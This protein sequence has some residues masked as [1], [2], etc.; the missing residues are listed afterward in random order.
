MTERLGIVDSMLELIGHIPLVRLQ[1]IGSD[2]GAEIL[3]KPEFLNPSGSIK[4]RIAK[5]MIE[6]AEAA[7][8][9]RHG[10]TII[11]ATS[12]NTGT[13]L[14]FV[15]AVKG[16]AMKA[17][18]P[19]VVANPTRM[20]IMLAYGAEMN[21]V[22]T[23][24]PLSSGAAHGG[25][26][27]LRGREICLELERDDP[28]LW[29]ARQF[30]SPENVEAHRDGTASEIL[31]STGGKLDMF[32][33]SV[34]TG[35]T[36]LGVAERLKEHDRNIQ[37][38]AVEPASSPMLQDPNSYPIVKGVSDGIIPEITKSGLMDRAVTVTNEDA[39]AMAHRLAREEGI[40][41]GMSG[42][43]N[44]AACVRLARELGPGKR[45]VTVLPDSRDRYLEVEKY[46]T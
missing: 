10:S 6:R 13:S 18:A 42:G 14:A 43:A 27:E 21:A 32:V 26:T 12:G 2:T 33:A 29:W 25:R 4:D 3:V 31:E 30:S 45:I 17:Y 28:S 41:T 22:D 5:L 20:A 35:G 44:V 19:T 24:G 46:T 16:Y 34:G 38:V 15:A 39:I 23:S 7:G 1:R 40:F 37:I 8:T 36:L 11:E 9:L